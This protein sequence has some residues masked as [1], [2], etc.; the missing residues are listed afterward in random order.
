MQ[1]G[2]EQC[3]DRIQ[4]SL[5]NSLDALST[6]PDHT[7]GEEHTHSSGVPSQS[8]E[9]IV[10]ESH[11]RCPSVFTIVTVISTIMAAIIGPLP[12]QRRLVTTSDPGASVVELSQTIFNT[13]PAVHPKLLLGSNHEH[14]PN[15]SS[16]L[17]T[18]E[19][20]IPLLLDG[21]IIR[22][23]SIEMIAF[24][25]IPPKPVPTMP[26]DSSGAS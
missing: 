12:D 11:R 15:S 20:C 5:E 16:V 19:V 13:C 8:T 17:M 2:Q 3:T 4:L 23:G 9:S 21:N 14:K 1:K 22:E 10:S 18:T 26:R 6:L 7:Q 25:V 24:D